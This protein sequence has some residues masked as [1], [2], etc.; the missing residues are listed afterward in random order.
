MNGIKRLFY[1]LIHQLYIAN[2]ISTLEVDQGMPICEVISETILSIRFSFVFINL[3]FPPLAAL[4][5]YAV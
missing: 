5:E 4:C 1:Q 3:P 2:H